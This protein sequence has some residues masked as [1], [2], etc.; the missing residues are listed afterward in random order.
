MVKAKRGGC[1]V[2]AGGY[3]PDGRVPTSR[4]LPTTVAPLT[5]AKQAFNEYYERTKAAQE[6]RARHAAKTWA[7]TW[8]AGLDYMLKN[9]LMGMI[10]GDEW[11][12]YE[13]CNWSALPEPLRE[14]LMLLGRTIERSF[15]GAPWR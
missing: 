15:R 8:W 12:R 14:D 9:C 1:A 4:H 5:P 7:A 13:G 6:F 11:R 10:V 3:L 2:I